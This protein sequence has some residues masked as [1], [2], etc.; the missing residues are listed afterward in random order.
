MRR[1]TRFATPG[2]EDPGLTGG[3]EPLKRA[4]AATE[5]ET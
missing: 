2:R 1:V 5:Q 4:V 3:P